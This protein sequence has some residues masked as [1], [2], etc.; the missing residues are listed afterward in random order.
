M[1]WF[2]LGLAVIAGLGALVWRQRRRGADWRREI[3]F[4]VDLV[5]LG[6]TALIVGALALVQLRDAPAPE[7]VAA[8]AQSTATR[9]ARP[10]RTPR[11]TPSPSRT[12]EEDADV[13]PTITISE[14]VEVSATVAASDPATT[15]HTVATGETLGA[16][17]AQY[18]VSLLALREANGITGDSLSVG[19]ELVIP[20]PTPV[21]SA[22]PEITA[23]LTV[24][25]TPTITATAEVTATATRTPRISPTSV[26]PTATT[27]TTTTTYTVQAGDTLRAIAERFGTTTAAI[28]AL[29]PG[30]NPDSLR[31]GAVLAI[32]TSGSGAGSA[33]AATSAPQRGTVNY[34][35]QQGDLLSTIARRFGVTTQQIIAANPAIDA[36]NLRV[37]QVL[38]IPNQPLP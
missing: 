14:T 17:A 3:S 5:A 8:A 18:D 24:E 30:L 22:T 38:R 25:A 4:F 23:T 13:S 31:V 29:N 37:G 27:S 33:P 15:T 28:V 12:V 21:A 35:V 26:P 7:P 1:L 6:A 20:L 34:T 19:Q 9:P 11:I 2:I 36:D 32:P 10:S 16:I